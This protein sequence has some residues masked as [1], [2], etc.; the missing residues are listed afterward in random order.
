M[1]YVC[2]TPSVL[3]SMDVCGNYMGARSMTDHKQLRRGG[4]ND[5]GKQPVTNDRNRICTYETHVIYLAMVH[6]SSS[7]ITFATWDTRIMVHGRCSTEFTAVHAPHIGSQGAG[8]R[9][10]Y[11]MLMV[12]SE[13]AHGHAY[14]TRPANGET[15][16]NG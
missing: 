7:N 4:S 15:R 8:P 16:L 3:C 6:A 10:A 14:T 12:I 1:V 2:V 5:G 11:L 13:H 9:C